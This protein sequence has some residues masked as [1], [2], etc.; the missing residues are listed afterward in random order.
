MFRNNYYCLVAGLREY[1]FDT[2]A[3]GF[4]APA[5]IDEVKEGVSARDR[6]RVE[7]FYRYWDIRNLLD[8]RA[9]RERFSPLSNLSR[10]EI[11]AAVDDPSLLPAPMARIAS[12]YRA[13][14][15]DGA[16]AAEDDVDTAGP[17]E[18][19]LFSAY[20]RECERSGCR[21]LKRWAEFDRTMRNVSA[22]LAARRLG[23]AP[24]E[25]IVGEGDVESALARSSAADFGLRGEVDYLEQVMA[26]ASEGGDML[27]K[28]RR[29]DEIRWN[30]ADELTSMN[31]FDIDFLLGYLAKVNIIYRW[32]SLDA[33]SGRR[34][35]ERLR[36]ELTAGG[37]GST[38]E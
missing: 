17:I 26:A 28:E 21:F 22:A 15:R 27:E 35:L 10:E 36:G 23:V 4:D 7:L 13:A 34:M 11:A 31:Y 29:M 16:D 8:A 37:A 14:E 20:Y 38:R 32:S 24:A 12:A 1:A 30:M 5:I 18:G 3:K 2:E 9:G 25:A 19:A 6:R 33:E